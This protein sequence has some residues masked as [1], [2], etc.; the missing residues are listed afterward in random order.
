[1]KICV[2]GPSKKF[3]SGITYFTIGLSNALNKEHDVSVLYLRNLIPGFLFPG[4]KRLGKN[5]SNVK[6]NKSI[7][8]YEGIDWYWIPSMFK[9]IRFLKKEK[10]DVIIFQWWT[11]SVAHSYLLLKIINKLFFKKKIIIEFHEVQD[12]AEVKIPLV[13]PYMKL[14]SKL[15]FKNFDAYVCHSNSDSKLLKKAYNLKKVS[16]VPHG[17]YNEL[18]KN[19]RIKKDP[20]V[21]NLLFFGLI[22][23]YK[24]LN[25]LIDAFDKIPK[26]KIK[27]YRLYI[28]GEAW[29]DTNPEELVEKSK[30]KEYITLINKYVPDEDVNKY[31]SLADV[32]VLPYTRASQSGAAHIATSYGI[33][34]IV[35]EVGG[36]KESM[37]DY[38]GTTFVKPKD[39][40]GIKNAILNLYQNRSK[41]YENPH[42][43]EKTTEKFEEIFKEIMK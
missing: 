12:T 41:R 39:T 15:L 16:I 22:R 42:S 8:Y 36:L 35:S 26:E 6:L 32:V 37:R 30:Y 7:N 11:G 43:W 14:M 10:P 1:M 27:N 34:V 29:E 2:I 19:I 9:A 21:C 28:V 24:G 33:P 38:K 23:Q 25:Y 3:L 17:S 31:F 40:T 4:H 18:K 13:K 20:N 5:I